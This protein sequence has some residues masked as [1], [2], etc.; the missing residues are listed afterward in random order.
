V[1]SSSVIATPDDDDAEQDPA[2]EQAIAEANVTL[3]ALQSNT[4]A[5]S[6]AATPTAGAGGQPGRKRTHS[7]MRAAS[8]GPTETATTTPAAS[9][10]NSPGDAT[11]STDSTSGGSPQFVGVTITPMD[12]SS[13]NGQQSQQEAEDEELVQTTT[14]IRPAKKSRGPS[15]ESPAEQTRS[16]HTEAP[17]R[18]PSVGPHHSFSPRTT[19]PSPILFG[20]GHFHG[21]ALGAAHS[22]SGRST[23]TF[24]AHPIIPMPYIQSTAF[25]P[26][27]G[28]TSMMLS[29]SAQ[30]HAMSTGI[31][32]SAASAFSFTPKLA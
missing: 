24:S 5:A 2:L 31:A 29:N 22:T 7:N 6:G 28:M 15:D 10:R 14:T 17:L 12:T 21:A 20:S 11:T 3:A 16:L 8:T 27:S 26:P 18:A 25:L 30:S 4:L 9:P 1:S 19:A 13:S 32:A 23:P